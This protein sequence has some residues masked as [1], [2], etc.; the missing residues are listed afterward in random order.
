[1]VLP[2]PR[3][4]R[5]RFDFVVAHHART[6]IG[7]A[8]ADRGLTSR[9]PYQLLRHPMYLGELVFRV[10]MIFSSPQLFTAIILS[11]VLAFIQCWRILREEKMIEGYTCY[12]RIVPWRFIPGLW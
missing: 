4:G 1:M 10:A 9:G 8:P 7:V 5:V 11:L 3:T 12:M 6:A 2:V